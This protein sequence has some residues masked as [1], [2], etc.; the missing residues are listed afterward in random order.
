MPKDFTWSSLR[1][2]AFAGEILVSASE[3][4]LPQ[5]RKYAKKSV[6]IPTPDNTVRNEPN[7]RG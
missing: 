6:W 1:L 2:C 7:T 5:K 4:S 3:E